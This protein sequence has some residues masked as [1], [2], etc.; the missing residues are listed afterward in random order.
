MSSLALPRIPRYVLRPMC[1]C[2]CVCVLYVCLD[3]VDVFPQVGGGG[4]GSV[5]IHLSSPLPPSSLGF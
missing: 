1:V 2:M 3:T 5:E 4:C